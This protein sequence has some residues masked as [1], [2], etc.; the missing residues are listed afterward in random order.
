MAVGKNKKAVSKKKGGKRKIVDP[1]SK[2]E[3]YDVKAPTAFPNRQ[4]C[5]TVVTKTIG[6]RLAVDGLKGRVFTANL[7]D[8]KTGAEEDA[9]RKFSFRVEEVQGK[10]CLSNFYGM[11]MTADKLRS[12]VRKWQSLIECN[13]DITTADGFKLR[14]FAIAFTKRRQNQA[15][16]TAYAQ[17]NQ[18]KNIRKK[19]VEIIQR[20]TNDELMKVCEKFM[21]ETIGK[22]IEKACMR[23]YPLQNV[24]IR[25][26]KA[27]RQPKM[28]MA[29][30]LELHGGAAAVAAMGQA[31]ARPDEEEAAP[32]AEAEAEAD[33]E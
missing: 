8:L 24:F 3:W 16:K 17:T 1:F 18:V 5:K 29:K 19:M 28:E 20:E 30:L 21:T 11:D 2:K 27:L 32:A 22:E 12:L 9:F 7:G 23:I 4:V 15:K 25:K 26:V 14:V 10:V 13:V 33:D 31:V 6:T